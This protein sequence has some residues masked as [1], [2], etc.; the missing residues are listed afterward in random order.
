MNTT[1]VGLSGTGFDAYWPQFPGLRERLEC[2][3]REVGAK[4]GRPGAEIVNLGLIDTPE[5]A[6]SA[7]HQLRQEIMDSF[8]VGGSFTE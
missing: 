2:Y 8:G 4:L 3:L 5:K 7:G 6:L 1:R